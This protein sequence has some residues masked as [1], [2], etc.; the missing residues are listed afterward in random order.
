MTYTKPQ[1]LAKGT[2][3]MAVCSP[4]SSP[5]GRPCNKPAPGGR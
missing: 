4:K 1:V 2:A 5:S 3:Q